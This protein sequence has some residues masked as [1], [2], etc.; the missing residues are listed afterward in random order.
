MCVQ[1]DM[2]TN[3][4]DHRCSCALQCDATTAEEATPLV[5][6]SLTTPGSDRT[7]K[8][9]ANH[10]SNWENNLHA[11]TL[12]CKEDNGRDG[13]A[14]VP[15]DKEACD[16]VKPAWGDGATKCNSVKRTAVDQSLTQACK[17]GAYGPDGITATDYD[18]GRL[19]LHLQRVYSM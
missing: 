15:A 12:F 9:K 2:N 4:A 14:S 8:C 13:Q 5:L 17:F 7:C 18:A 19:L 10:Y 1:T 16:A 11:T 6:G 3:G